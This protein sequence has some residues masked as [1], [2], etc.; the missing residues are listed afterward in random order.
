L[1][2]FL[3]YAEGVAGLLFGGLACF[4]VGYGDCAVFGGYD[5]FWVEA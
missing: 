3:D 2:L 1:E 4:C 5:C